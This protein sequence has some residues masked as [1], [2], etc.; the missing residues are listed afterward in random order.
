MAFYDDAKSA[1]EREF[2]FV[3]L[4]CYI[5]D[6]NGHWVD[7]TDYL[8]ETGKDLLQKLLGT[9]S[10]KNEK[11]AG[12]GGVSTSSISASFVNIDGFF[13]RPFA[14]LKTIHG[15]DASF[16]DSYRNRQSVLYNHEIKFTAKV[17]IVGAQ[18]GFYEFSLGHFLINSVKR[19]R[20]LV[21]I[22]AVNK[23]RP[24][25]VKNSAEKVKDGI[26]WYSNKPVLFLVKELL[27]T[28]YL[29][30]DGDLSD[31]FI[32]PDR[33]NIKTAAY[34]RGDSGDQRG[35]SIY[36]R[37]PEWDGSMWR[38][39][40]LICR[41][42]LV[43]QRNTHLGG[44]SPYA[45]VNNDEVLY[46]GCDNELWYFDE[47]TD[48]YTHLGD[49]PEGWLIRRIFYSQ[50]DN[51]LIIVAW[52]A[53]SDT[54]RN[55]T[56]RIYKY[57]GS[58]ISLFTADYNVFVGDYCYRDGRLSGGTLFL[59]GKASPS[60]GGENIPIPIKQRVISTVYTGALYWEKVD[61]ISDTTSSW[62]DGT[63]D[64][65]A[66]P[67][68]YTFTASGISQ[69]VGIRFS[70][71]QEGC[72]LFSNSESCIIYFVWDSGAEVYKAKKLEVK[73]TP[74]FTELFDIDDGEGAEFAP[75]SG[76]VDGSNF[77]VGMVA[78]NSEAT[79]R[80]SVTRLVKYN[81]STDTLTT[82][83]SP[84]D[85]G[86]MGVPTGMAVLGDYL[87]ITLF[88]RNRIGYSDEY[89]LHRIS[90]TSTNS[91]SYGTELRAFSSP[92][93]GITAGSDEV[94]F[95]D[96]SSS[97]AYKCIGSTGEVELL[98]NGYPAVYED[99]WLASNLAID[100]NLRSTEIVYGVSAPTLIDESVPASGKYVLWKYDVYLTDR[101]EL[102][103]FTNMSI[104]QA[105]EQL[106]VFAN[107]VFGFTLDGNFYF[108]SRD[109]VADNVLTLRND[110]QKSY[111]QKLEIESGETE[112]YN[113]VEII[114]NEAFLPEPEGELR[115][116]A[117]GEDEANFDS[118][119]FITQFDDRRKFIRLV[120]LT[121]GK[122][123]E[124]SIYFKYRA[125]VEQF[126]TRL[127]TAASTGDS[128]IYILSGIDEVEQ[129]DTIKMRSDNGEVDEIEV[130]SAPSDSDIAAGKVTLL[131]ALS[132]DYSVGAYV[133]ITKNISEWSDKRKNLLTNPYFE[134]WSGGNP[135]GWTATNCSATEETTEY[136]FGQR[137]CKLINSADEGYISQTLAASSFERGG[138][139]T[140]LAYIK[141]F[142]G[143]TTYPKA[144]AYLD[145]S[146]IGISFTKQTHQ[147][148]AEFA[149]LSGTFVYPSDSSPSVIVKVG[150][151]ED[152]AKIFVGAVFLK[153]GASA[154]PD[155]LVV[156]SNDFLYKIGRTN[157]GIKFSPQNTE[158]PIKEGDQILISCQGLSLRESAG[159]TIR[160][161]NAS[162]IAKYG[163]IEFPENKLKFI[164]GR[165][166]LD[167]AERILADFAYPR[168]KFNI[169]C[170]FLPWLDFVSGS[171]LQGIAIRDR[172]VLPLSEHW[173]ET[174]I[175]KAIQH[176]VSEKSK[177]TLVLRA[178][179]P[180]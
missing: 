39:D 87:Y 13:D 34:A 166:A 163:R 6:S 102:A 46:M 64:F 68:Y 120:S 155:Y 126:E 45:Y 71:G 53:L 116:V 157:V 131:S 143:D 178:V 59:G 77:Y 73:D 107:A 115:L 55:I 129:G 4:K 25:R 29:E 145:I 172:S 50:Y 122:I 119:I 63:I 94:Y 161:L 132:N 60:A 137:S 84:D 62:D 179:S 27:K 156:A 70:F 176:S 82:V 146:A 81:L 112:V 174:C 140:I 150:I 57:D 133:E 95:L 14:G 19:T 175:I 93:K 103:D 69:G 58:S 38:N 142:G 49:L 104:W 154:S 17:K 7:F 134:E 66:E 47:R 90:K 24:L 86:K 1:L 40:G 42:L 8:E 162:S 151:E 88:W 16:D 80:R 37:P 139:Y 15:E 110:E 75:V 56:I 113:Y 43:C 127:K 18:E 91:T 5:K 153:K 32:F 158:T 124:R 30:S 83:V 108:L 148:T 10:L 85:D 171:Q 147:V 44:S 144:T 72:V 2:T 111:I 67:G 160:V 78:W 101:V 31:S 106:A 35:L 169:T 3:G 170:R 128:V 9:I 52:E 130:A 168:F 100:S 138:T 98:D 22:Y 167:F 65:M 79:W 136:M 165:R 177:T 51:Q 123:S 125:Y 20:H 28:K 11:R 97:T 48:T 121:T 54:D 152:D 74:T 41:A 173:Q 26:S 23:G 33:F 118:D 61:S 21:T 76:C 114:P 159:A 36:G 135:V 141:T 149:E 99:P 89:T 12:V 96:V 109:S 92:I 180:Y 117:R 164:A 105:L